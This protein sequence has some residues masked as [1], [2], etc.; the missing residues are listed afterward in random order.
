MK[1]IV[2]SILLLF[3]V[4]MTHAQSPNLQ[5]ANLELIPGCHVIICNN[6]TINMSSGLNFD[7]TKGVIVD[8]NNGTI[9]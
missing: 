4:C 2:L 7:A 6:G 3:V 1:K 5:N 9:N 8:V